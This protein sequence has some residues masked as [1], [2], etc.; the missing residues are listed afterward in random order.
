ML[1]TYPKAYAALHAPPSCVRCQFRIDPP[2]QTTTTADMV[3]PLAE[4]AVQYRIF[5]PK[6]QEIRRLG[7]ETKS[8]LDWRIT[9]KSRG[10]EYRV[11]D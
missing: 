3:E 6:Y 10:Y 2:S 1:T 7:D 8:I 5:C 11:D 4:V 9:S